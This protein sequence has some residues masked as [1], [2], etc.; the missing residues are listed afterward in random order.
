MKNLIAHPLVVLR[1]ALLISLIIG[2]VVVVG[3]P[4]KPAHALTTITQW[5][6]DYPNTT[7]PAP[8]TGTGIASL[9]GT[10]APSGSFAGLPGNGWQT[11]SY[12]TQ[13]TGNKT[14]GVQF[15]I[16]TTGWQDIE[17]SFNI[18]HSNASANTIVVRY[19]TDGGS[20]FTDVA[21]Y[22]V[23]AGDTWYTRTVDLSSYP[24]VNNI[25]DL[26]VRVVSSF[27]PP[28]NTQY[29]A[30]NH[31]TSTYGTS[32]ALRFDN[33]TFRGNTIASDAAPAVSAVTPPNGA[34]NVPVNS[35]VVITFSEP[36][37]V[38]GDWFSLACGTSG[39]RTPGA[40]NVTVTGG[41]TVFTLDPDSDFA[42]G[43]TCTLTVFAAQVTDQDTD[44]PPDN[45]A[46]DF[47]SSFTTQ[48]PLPDICTNPNHPALTPIN[49]VQ[50]SGL[51]SPLSGTV[52]TVRGIVVGDF[53][54]NAGLQ[55]FY[56]QSEVPDSDPNTS[57][58]LFV[59]NGNN[60]TVSL[61]DLVVVTDTVRETFNQTRL[62]NAPIILVCGPA[63]LP[64]PTDVTLPF[65][66]PDAPEAF[67]GMRV[68]LPQNLTVTDNYFLG[69][70]G[71]VTLSFGG[72]LQQ[73]TQITTPGTLA[74]ALQ[75]A[76]DLNRI[77]LDDTTNQQ[78]PDP[79]IFARNGLTLTAANTLR[80]GDTVSNVVGVMTYG[81]GGASASPDAYRVRPTGPVTFT[82]ANPRPA[83]PLPVGG[84][85]RVASVNLLNYFN[86][87]G[88]GNCTL[89]VGGGATDCRGADNAAEFTRQVSKTIPMLLGLNAD[90]IGLME[91]ENDGYGPASAIQDLVNRL[92]AATAPGTYAF[93]NPDAALG[94]TNTLGVDAIKVGFIYRPARVTPVGQ[95]AVL[96]SGAFGLFTLTDNSQIQRNRP[97]LAQ[98]FQDNATGARFTA[99]VNHFKSKGSS[100]ANNQSPVGPDPDTGDGQGNCNLTRTAAAQQLAAWLATVPT[101]I[102]DPDILILGDLNSYAKEDPITALK[103]AGYINL[104]EDRLGLTSYSY[105]FQ[106]QWGTLDY[107]LASPSLNPQVTGIAKWHINAD[108]PV[109]LDYNTNF[110]STAQQSYFYSP[111]PYRSSDHDVILVGLLLNDAPQLSAVATYDTGLGGNGAEIISVRDDRGALSNAGDSS[112]DLLD[113]GDI[114]SPTLI[115]RVGPSAALSDLNSLAIHPSKDLLLAVAGKAVSSTNPIN[116]KVLAYRLSTGAF[117][118]EAL[119][120]IQ[121]DAIGISPDGNYAVVANEA[122]APDQNDNGGPGS[123][124]IIDLS[125]FD[126]DSP[127]PLNVITLSLPS[128]ASTP[129][130]SSGRYDDIGR[131]LIDNI[132][133]T[134]EPESVAFSADS[135][136]AFVSLQENNGIAR[137][138]LSPPYTLTFFGLYSTTHLADLTNGGG[139]NPVETLTAWREPDG[140]TV[141]DIAG[142]RYVITADEGDTRPTAGNAG[143]RGGRTVSLFR[144]DDGSFVADTAGSL[145]D[146][147]ARWGRYPD[148]RSSRGGS[149]PEVVDG[150]LFNGQAIVA[151]GL[152]RANAVVIID[153]SQPQTPTLLSLIP[154]G[155]AP[156]GVKLVARNQALYVLAANE[157][158]GTL[159]IARVPVGQHI[160]TQ[161]RT[162]ISAFPLHDLVVL[163]PDFGD[164]F[165]VTLTLNPALGGLALTP[166]GGA[167]GAFDV[168]NGV[169]T[170]TGPIT[171]VN[172]TLAGALFTP[173][174]GYSGTVV[175]T[176]T[177][178]D[179]AASDTGLV[180]LLI[181]ASANLTL[182]AAPDT[183][184]VGNL[185]TIT[186]TVTDSSNNPVPDGTVVSFTTDLGNISPAS[187]TTVNGVATATLSSTVAGVATVT[188]TVGSLS[189][190]AQVT[191]VVPTSVTLV[192]APSTLPVGSLSTLTATVFDQFNNP[193][194]DGVVV[195]FTTDFGALSSSSA[196][197]V[198]GVAT[199]TLSSTLP[200]MAVVTATVG[201]VSATV[202][203]TFTVG[204]P[205][206]VAPVAVPSTLLVSNSST[207][208]ATVTDQYGNVVADGTVVSFTTDLGNISPVTAT[209]IGGVATATLSST[210]AG[211]ATVT[212]TVGSLSATAQV[213]FV[214]PTSITLVAA[215]STLP[216]G[217]L[218]TLTATV[219]DQFNNPIA[220]GVVVSFTTDLGNISPASATTV[221]GVATAT[222]SSTVAGVATVT[223]TVNGLSATAQVTFV[224]PTSVTLVAAPSTLPVGSLSTLT[225]T[226][227]DQFNNPI[228]DGVVVSFTTDLGN[229]SPASATTVNGVATATLSSTVAGVATVTATVNGLSATAQVTFVVPTSVT[230]VAAPSTLPVG[231]LS[232]LTATVF[233]QFNN[234][235]ADGVV[236]SFTTDFGALSSSSATTVNGTA[237]VTLSS[238]LPGVAT[239]TATV[240]SLSAT[241]EVTFTVGAPANVTLV[242]LPSTLPVGSL[243][244][245]TATVT[246]QYGNVVADGTLVSFTTDLGNVSPASATT[247]NGVATA[248]LSSTVAG[249]ATVTATVGSLSATAQVTFTPDVPANVALVAVPSTLPVD[250][251]STLTAT[252]TDQFGNPV[253]DGTTVNFTTSLGTLSG[254][255]ATTVNG[256]A[257]VTLSS[258]LP[259][260]AVVT[261]TVGSLNATTQ[262]TFTA[263][264]PFSVTLVA[265]PS[266]LPVGSLST[267]TATVTDQFGNFVANGTVVNFTTSLG[268]LSGSSATTVNGV[269]TVTLSSTLPGVAVVT[270]TVGSLSATRLVTFTTGPA[271]QLLL[272]ATPALIFANGISQSTVLATVRDAFG[273]PVPNAVVN[274]LAGIGQFSP[275]SGSTNANG[276][277]TATL[278]SIFPATENIFA[279]V[280]TLVAQTPVTYQ[281]PPTSQLG[282]NGNLTT[283]TQ[284]LGVVRKNDLI[285]Y[286]VTITNSGNGAVNNIL[287]VAP[288]PNG[289]AY[290]PGSASGGNFSGLNLMGMEEVFGPQAVQNAVVWSGSLGPG[291]AHTLSYVVQVLILEGQIINQPQVY[292]NNQNTGINLSS[293]VQVE[294]RKAYFP[295]VRRQ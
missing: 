136:F 243:S 21:T 227:F 33:V 254:S 212:A 204:A 295:I 127:T 192:A 282:L 107:A 152:E 84:S 274:F 236:V 131:L 293:T 237:T 106:G 2:Q 146:L 154:T 279:T 52:V 164:T 234:P 45:M 261:A 79:V 286:T 71:Q 208:T 96:T 67:E 182:T 278:T 166:T 69:R 241:V 70:F 140:V 172:A 122:E 142:D 117:I 200:G 292:V 225:A 290:V 239:V 220:D 13:G 68:R 175:I 258:T 235:I 267:L 24:A 65:S 133:N 155:A 64:A 124:S 244:T 276:E 110:K 264:A 138:E 174:L 149:E 148:N 270:A 196:T 141:L 62:G 49:Q 218:S 238:T 40:N 34:T 139:Y 176:A 171:G 42:Q 145:D 277:V 211:V 111:D 93:I 126:P 119:V 112:F 31:P 7:M 256:V 178:T 185:S 170:V 246:D 209:T 245:L 160:F 157:V 8:S 206:N 26:R 23:N 20:T 289:T 51:T 38:N 6:F 273:N 272:T 100:C 109:V 230:L 15:Q 85:L 210:V 153:V 12:P 63:P 102:N 265:V 19:S 39:T 99:V 248:T 104:A 58:G 88:A 56:I 180:T 118:T 61:G 29:V 255:S 27:A 263:G 17:F 259:G 193:I 130:F 242:A 82:A 222:L 81:W 283:V 207:L 284:T 287:L 60:N 47:T 165:T 120:G 162:T 291:A 83:A 203:V 161:Q 201:S 9:V 59:F 169:Y 252:V 57:E 151:V 121:P 3:T 226:V 229:I 87:F 188:A 232:T 48:S 103:N 108:E 101:G 94:V 98:S 35:N 159:T 114:L 132:T 5:T 240:G 158:S 189:A 214:V 75:A 129:G 97:A 271:A 233:D 249:V 280:G 25:P 216:V 257:T 41:P 190:T 113:L 215:P 89:G 251:L 260:V 250:N 285:T 213:T 125:S 4:A 134:L 269:A 77:I 221:N 92:N 266:T 228:A 268:T 44:D 150:I 195:S 199:V 163:D 72:R 43:E 95:T 37:N 181:N 50:G 191:F 123:I 46:A 144:A 18:R 247:V 1:L 30:S 147:A 54:T 28:T 187:A 14:A 16:S 55:G 253:A 22:T 32:G 86:T 78:N 53:E 128:Q 288:I 116:G 183:L 219:F 135:Q 262:V 156:E 179:G 66:S 76:N 143:V 137:V 177:A 184:P 80:G 197:T 91:L 115:Q 186:A 202:E 74:N 167:S 217:S 36:V 281:L 294:A 205:A 73:P 224:V 231:S 223:A 105:S 194:A 173:T 198:N 275:T 90:V 11:T 10:T 168:A